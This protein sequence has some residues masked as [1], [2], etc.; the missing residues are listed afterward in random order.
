[1]YVYRI[2]DLAGAAP[3]CDGDAPAPIAMITPGGG[4]LDVD[5]LAGEA[6][7]FGAALAVGDLATDDDGPELIVGA[8]GAK[9]DGI[10]DAGAAYVYRGA[11]L[12]ADGTAPV[13][14]QVADS[15]PEENQRFGGGVAAAPMAGR[16]ELLVGAVGKGRVFIAYC[17]GV[18]EDIEEGADVTRNATGE[19][20]ST[21][22]RPR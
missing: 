17:T 18:G 11:D 8:P 2:S 3:T 4:P 12:L 15:T 1:V 7:D 21:R 14:G 13:A 9:V 19:V 10:G 16:A 5:C 22:C 20:V 6:C